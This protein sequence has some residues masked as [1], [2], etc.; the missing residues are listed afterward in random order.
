MENI[1]TMNIMRMEEIIEGIRKRQ[2]EKQ[3]SNNRE[4]RILTDSTNRKPRKRKQVGN[5]EPNMK[6][7]SVH[8][9][10]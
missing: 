8:L 4:N 5:V 9:L 2:R 7:I 6:Q 10:I 3:G 1:I